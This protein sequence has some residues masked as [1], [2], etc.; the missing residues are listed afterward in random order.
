LA[1]L[2]TPR[3]TP[4]QSLAAVE[5]VPSIPG[6]LD[7]NG[8]VEFADFVTLSNNFDQRVLR[9][10]QGDLDGDRRV[11]FSDFVILASNYGKRV[12]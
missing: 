6:D 7:G 1:D 5:V 12:S 11:E 9:R 10:S 2:S 8:A 3:P 4:C